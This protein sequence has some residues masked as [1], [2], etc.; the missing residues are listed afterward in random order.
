MVL[1]MVDKKIVSLTRPP[2]AE[3]CARLM[4]TTILDASPEAGLQRVRCLV[5]CTPVLKPLALPTPCKQ[6]AHY[7]PHLLHEKGDTISYWNFHMLSCVV[8]SIYKYQHLIMMLG[9]RWNIVR[10]MVGT[11]AWRTW[12]CLHSQT[13][14]PGAY[15]T[16]GAVALARRQCC[17]RLEG[18]D[19][20]DISAAIN[21]PL[22][23]SRPWLRPFLR[24]RR[25]RRQ[26]S[27]VVSALH[28]PS[29]WYGAARRSMDAVR[30]Q[31]AD[32]SWFLS[33]APLCTAGSCPTHT[34]LSPGSGLG[35][36]VPPGA[37]AAEKKP[38]LVLRGTSPA[39]SAPVRGARAE[40]KEL[41]RAVQPD[42]AKMV[43]L[44]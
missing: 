16:E 13:L 19:S 8:I 42:C 15:P 40:A 10:G 31:Q 24:F 33:P 29:W 44:C 23:L 7:R 2:A 28:L 20:L 26:G 4:S 5:P 39:L 11:A 17:I 12:V 36:G 43:G 9:T 18:E 27:S 41:G 14:S 30:P 34:L 22:P 3:L 1:H 35:F 37:A 38:K 32:Y 21:Q 25:Q 6:L